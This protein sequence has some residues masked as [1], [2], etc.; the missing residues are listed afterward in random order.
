MNNCKIKVPR[1]VHNRKAKAQRT[2][3][4]KEAKDLLNVELNRVKE[5]MR[6]YEEIK[7]A[8]NEG[9]L[10]AKGILDFLG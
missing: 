3:Q 9:D 1:I 6:E 8:A 5:L 7:K 2:A 4:H 10:Q